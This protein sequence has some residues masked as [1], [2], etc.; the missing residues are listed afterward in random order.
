[1]ENKKLQ[2]MNLLSTFQSILSQLHFLKQPNRI[3]LISAVKLWIRS[4][5]IIINPLSWMFSVSC[6][7]C[8]LWVLTMYWWCIDDVLTIYWRCIDDVSSQE[9][10]L[11]V[12]CRGSWSRVRSTTS[13]QERSSLKTRSTSRCPTTT[14][15]PT[16]PRHT[17]VRTEYYVWSV[18]LEMDRHSD[19]PP[20][21]CGPDGGPPCFPG[22]GP[23]AAGSVGQ[24]SLSDG[25]G[26]GGGLHHP[27]SPPLHWQ[28]ASGHRPDLRHH[29][30]LLQPNASWVITR[31]EK[32]IQDV[33]KKWKQP[34]TCLNQGK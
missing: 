2:N 23:A 19:P 11:T 20:P 14:S 15:R 8:W 17:W 29:N 24:R 18:W 31:Q 16:S 21:P 10:Q 7:S 22:E 27:G 4:L 6:R 34:L 32:L 3:V 1:M 9:L 33:L 12:S 13:T 28:R 26:D 5:L 25:E 30:A